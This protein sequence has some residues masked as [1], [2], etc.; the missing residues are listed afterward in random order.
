MEFFILDF[1]FDKPLSFLSNQHANTNE[2]RLATWKDMTLPDMEISL[3][4]LLDKTNW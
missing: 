4:E 1:R 2:A 3:Y